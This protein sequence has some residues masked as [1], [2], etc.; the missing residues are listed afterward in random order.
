M[1]PEYPKKYKDE[2][3]GVD[4]DIL[5][6][7]Y[8]ITAQAK[9]N[10]IGGQSNQKILDEVSFE[11]S[12]GEIMAVLGPNGAGKST[13][14]KI[15]GGIFQGIWQGFNH[16]LSFSGQCRLN[17]LDLFSMEPRQRARW[18]AYVAADIYTEFPLTAHETVLLGRTPYASGLLRKISQEDHKVAK[19]AMERCFCWNLKDRDLHTLSGGERQLVACARAFAQQ[20]RILLLDESLSKMDLNHQAMIGGLLKAFTHEKKGAVLLV[21]H[22]INLVLGWA[23]TALLLKKGKHIAYG[24]LKAALTER[25][26]GTLYP[27]TDFMLGT[28][29]VT[30]APQVFFK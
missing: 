21:S 9:H 26:L 8:G 3:R 22:D 16:E 6:G 11:V 13:L 29:P 10:Q 18:I 19:E 28:N 15:I 4:L 27:G 1:N 20:A 24:T 5:L 7:V 17:K 14:L 2:D 25:N 12:R 30:G 23:D